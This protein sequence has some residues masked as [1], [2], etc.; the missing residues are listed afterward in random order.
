M[1]GATAKAWE[2][3]SR[4]GP[5]HDLR[6]FGSNQ[7][8]KDGD[9]TRTSNSI[10]G[11]I[12]NWEELAK[13]H[14]HGK[15]STK[16]NRNGKTH[17]GIR[18]RVPQWA[19]TQTNWWV[20]AKYL[21][22]YG[23]VKWGF[24]P[25]EEAKATQAR[26]IEEF[27]NEFT[28]GRNG[29]HITIQATTTQTRRNRR[30]GGKRGNRGRAKARRTNKATKKDNRTPASVGAKSAQPVSRGRNPDDSTGSAVTTDDL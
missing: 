27:G 19:F 30:R 6:L 4:D 28:V 16:G 13:N 22:S 17:G 21:T 5:Q 14:P 26:L 25:I 24:C 12:P 23:W 29:E 11:D 10:R 18:F 3:M 9:A 20:H 1:A 7:F 15:T 2:F 8:T